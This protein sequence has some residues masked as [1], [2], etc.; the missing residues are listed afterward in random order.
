MQKEVRAFKSGFGAKS[1]PEDTGKRQAGGA[2]DISVTHQRAHVS[3][4]Q[5]RSLHEALGNK[6]PHFRVLT[7]SHQFLP[8]AVRNYGC[9]TERGAKL[10]PVCVH[11]MAHPSLFLLVFQTSVCC[12]GYYGHMCEMCPGKPGRWCSGNGQCQD[13]LQGSGECRCL[14]GFH[15]TACEMCEVGRFGADCKSGDTGGWGSLALPNCLQVQKGGHVSALRRP[16]GRA[17]RCQDS[18][19]GKWLPGL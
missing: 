6:A 13:G 8:R 3:Q 18:E 7:P 4:G 5:C 1:P 9:H 15:G 17:E 2:Q 19:T 11:R 12:P 16:G 10:C 14:E